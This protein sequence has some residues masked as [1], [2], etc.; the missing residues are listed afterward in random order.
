L[1]YQPQTILEAL[2]YEFIRTGDFAR[3]VF[4]R[5]EQALAAGRIMKAI[6]EAKSPRLSDLA[7]KM[8][9]TPAA[10]Y[11][12]IQRFLGQTDTK[13]A[14][15]RLFQAE[16]PFVIGDP[17][18]IPRPEAE[19]TSYVGTL[20]DGQTRGFWLLVLATPYRGR[21]IPCSFVTYS[22][23]TIAEESSSR[24]L[25]HFAAFA[26]VKELLGERPLVLD[27][28]FSYGLLLENLVAEKINFVIRLKLGSHP[29]TF[30]DET[31]RQIKLVI[32]QGTRQVYYQLY[33]QGEV[34]VNLIGVWKKGLERPLWIMSNLDPDRAL[35]IYLAR[36]KIEESFKD[37]KN[38]LCVDKI[39]NKTRDNMEKMIA[40]M[41][42][43]YSVGLLTG[44]AIRD[45]MYTDPSGRR[46]KEWYLFSGLFV[47]LKQ[48]ILLASKARREVMRRVKEAFGLLVFD[49][50]RI[51][52]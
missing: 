47:L 48:K 29:P 49:S 36:T 18:E 8:P 31:G 40:M 46:R 33:Y 43:T 37:L 16:A 20:S 9:G 34:A 21:A 19:K 51:P 23:R 1:L 35:E 30:L 28:E 12:Q 26:T 50:V 3:Y 32:A 44:E 24:N 7:Q 22:S 13:A 14:L 5:D 38:L 15:E 6:L 39:M 11:K 4:D 2:M 52:V 10:N 41:L 17:T 27:R 25:E 45:E 42:I